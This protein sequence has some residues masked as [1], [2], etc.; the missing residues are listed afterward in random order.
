M[1]NPVSGTKVIQKMGKVN[2]FCITYNYCLQSY[3]V[4]IATVM[5]LA[6]NGVLHSLLR[7]HGAP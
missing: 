5:T 6:L 3:S 4:I 7:A 2:N 1:L